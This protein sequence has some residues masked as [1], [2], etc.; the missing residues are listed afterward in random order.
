VSSDETDGE[1][2]VEWPSAS[3]RDLDA[4]N[5]RL[6]YLVRASELLSA[7]LDHRA[8]VVAIADLAV[9]DLA[10]TCAVHLVQDRDLVLVAA[11]HVDQGRHR[12][13]HGLAARREPSDD[14]TAREALTHGGPIVDQTARRVWLPLRRHGRTLGVLALSMEGSHRPLGKAE[15]PLIEDLGHRSAVALDHALRYRDRTM[16]AQTL[17]RS[18]LPPSL[19][20]IPGI[21]LASRYRAAGDGHQVGGDFFDVFPVGDDG[22]AIVMGD[23]SGKGVVAAGLTALARYTARAVSIGSTRPS[24]VL[25]ATNEAVLAADVGERF[26]TMAHARMRVGLDEVV[27]DLA[28]GG[29]PRPLLLAASGEVRPVGVPGTVI[30]LFPDCDV[31]DARVSLGP[32]DALV[33]FTD[34][35][36]EARAPNGG[37]SDG[38][39]D[40]V[41]ADSAGDDAAGIASAIEA[42]VLRFEDD[43]PRDDIGL[44]VVRVPTAAEAVIGEVL[45][46]RLPTEPIAAYMARGLART[47]LE[48]HPLPAEVADDIVL[49]VS[50]LVTNAARV[51]NDRVELRMWRTKAVVVVEVADDGE[52]F[53]PP[54]DAS[55][56]PAPQAEAGRGLWLVQMLSDHNQFNPGPWGTVARCRFVVAV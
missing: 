10:D 16:E 48:S 14:A 33:L 19:P 29:H 30:G 40:A 26:C 25:A 2:E 3:A 55:L 35:L 28:L 51:A 53:V 52:G 18:L 34:G 21:Q 49:V 37:W 45:A 31:T 27:I 17:Q 5:R 22:W 11:A 46:R 6:A 9:P 44:V 32:G 38:L 8:T 41:L 39:L 23:V 36:I 4:A 12:V 13:L 7:S 43:D 54:P 24:E 50:E 15:L 42:A 20:I 1:D 47:W 56:A